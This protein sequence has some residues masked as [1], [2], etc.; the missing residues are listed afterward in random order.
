MSTTEQSPSGRAYHAALY[1]THGRR[2]HKHRVVLYLG[3]DK[4]W[5]ERSRARNGNPAWAQLL[6]APETAAAAEYRDHSPRAT[7]LQYSGHAPAD[8]DGLRADL[9]AL[10]FSPEVVAQFV[11]AAAPYLN[12]TA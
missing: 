10:E 1:F 3:W 11:T 8:L 4:D 2:A 9:A 7:S 6:I 12:R 5:S